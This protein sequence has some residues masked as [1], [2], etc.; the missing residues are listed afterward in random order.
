MAA[1]DNTALENIV[2]TIRAEAG[3]VDMTR[4]VYLGFCSRLG[5][6]PLSDFEIERYVKPAPLTADISEIGMYTWS[7][8]RRTFE[9]ATVGKLAASLGGWRYTGICRGL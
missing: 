9:D 8:Y 5:I 4:E 6:S 2:E 7:K 1:S 3:Y